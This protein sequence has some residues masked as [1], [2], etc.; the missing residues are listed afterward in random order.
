M[1]TDNTFKLS[2]VLEK[3]LASEDLLINQK[4]SP[5][6]NIMQANCLFLFVY[7]CLFYFVRFIPGGPGLSSI[8]GVVGFGE[9]V[10]VLSPANS[11]V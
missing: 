5:P 6:A 7:F 1:I 10:I 3:T 8:Y 2:K 9:T 11:A 4:N